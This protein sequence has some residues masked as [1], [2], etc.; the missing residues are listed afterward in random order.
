[1]SDF[2]KPSLVFSTDPSQQQRDVYL[3]AGDLRKALRGVPDDTP[4]GQERIE[5]IY[6][7]THSWMTTSFPGNTI[8]GG[9]VMPSDFIRCFTAWYDSENEVFLLTPHY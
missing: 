6:F 2:K 8:L 7:D 1:V 5:D 9:Q 3:T 4:I